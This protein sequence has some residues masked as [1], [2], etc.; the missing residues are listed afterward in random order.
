MWL[1][2]EEREY[3]LFIA[4]GGCHV[5]AR[6]KGENISKKNHELSLSQSVIRVEKI[7]VIIVLLW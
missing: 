7:R 1:S 6:I 4:P 2:D 5:D 3:S